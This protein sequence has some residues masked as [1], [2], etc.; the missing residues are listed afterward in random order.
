MAN[1]LQGFWR[2]LTPEQR[3]ELC[4]QVNATLGHLRHVFGGRRPAGPTLA[5][6]IEKA[7][8]GAVSR[9]LLRPDIYG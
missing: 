7:T 2:S 4:S 5:K 9:E 1:D 3:A 8:A 6:D